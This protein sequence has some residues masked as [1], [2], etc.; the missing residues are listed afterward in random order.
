MEDN[1]LCFVR[2][3]PKSYPVL[4]TIQ[5]W[6]LRDLV[7]CPRR[8]DEFLYVHGNNVISYDTTMR[9]GKALLRKLAFAPTSMACAEG[10]LAAGGQ[11]SQL[12]VRSLDS[13]YYAETSVGGSINNALCI[14][15]H[16]NGDT[17]LLVCNNDE[18][19]KVLSLP[20]LSAVESIS[21]PTAVNHAAV[22]PDGT[23]MLAVGD[24][25]VVFLY[26]ISNSGAYS[27]MATLTVSTDGGFSSA[28]SA[29]SEKFAVASQDGTVAV[30][31]VRSTERLAR[32]T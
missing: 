13:D 6:Q 10:Y 14:A 26:G 32:F 17:R 16:A 4:A 8:A 11:R 28:W 23:R 30:W 31:D 12:V 18:K 19:I 20:E 9:R 22:S 15:R 7:V 25:N 21:F 27:R 3:N 29:T 1:A 5:H 24:T 2:P